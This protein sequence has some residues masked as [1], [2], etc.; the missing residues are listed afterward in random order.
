MKTMKDFWDKR[1]SEK[2]FAYGT[3]PN[4][5]FAKEIKKLQPGKLLLPG[6]GEGRNAVFAA[7][8]GW[9][10]TAVDF[11]ESAKEKATKLAEENNV[12]IE[13]IIDDL[14]GYNPREEYFD[15][16]SLI[17]VHL[18]EEI[19]EN[20]H[21]RIVKAL[22]PG[23]VFI[24]EFFA[25]EQINKNSGGPKNLEMLYGMDEIY[26]DFHELELLKFDKETTELNEGNCHKG[27][28]EVIR[29]V[30]AKN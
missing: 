22:K 3:A 9:D 5:F 20:L 6:E 16:I 14:G 30:A 19:R 15:V 26:S 1:F 12:K 13:Y 10:V 18:P 7:L 25:K 4:L 23:G 29:I 2:N 11:S 28:A 17:F 8:N 27:F 24:G 21:T